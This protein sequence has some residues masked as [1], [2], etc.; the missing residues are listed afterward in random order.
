MLIETY[1]GILGE[2][3]QA[4]INLLLILTP[5]SYRLWRERIIHHGSPCVVEWCARSSSGT[6]APGNRA[7]SAHA[8]SPTSWRRP[9]AASPLA[10]RARRSIAPSVPCA[11]P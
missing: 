3:K 8:G 2:L 1:F 11:H 9:G 4:V 6:A 5:R 10:R 7:Q